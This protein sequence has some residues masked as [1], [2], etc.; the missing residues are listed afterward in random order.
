MLR[1]VGSFRRATGTNEIV[2]N[3]GFKR[4]IDSAVTAPQELILSALNR[5]IL[6]GEL[7]NWEF[8]YVICKV[9]PLRNLQRSKVNEELVELIEYSPTGG[10]SLLMLSETFSERVTVSKGDD[11][12]TPLKVFC[13]AEGEKLHERVPCRSVGD[14][15]A[16]SDWLLVNVLRLCS[17][18]GECVIESYEAE[19]NAESVELPTFVRDEPML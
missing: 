14:F 4:S 17:S 18:E 11:V 2:F 8:E 9:E 6:S 12:A 19:A 10:R 1:Q 7:I 13:V 16:V 15:V 3:T 5:I